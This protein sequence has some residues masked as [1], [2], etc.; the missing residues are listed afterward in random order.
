M[1]DPDVTED[2]ESV[3]FLI[4]AEL[5]RGNT[6]SAQKIFVQHQ[7]ADV[8]GRR[9]HSMMYKLLTPL[10]SPCMRWQTVFGDNCVQRG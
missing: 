3:L 6:S 9:L 7:M 4:D 8:R 1:N 10:L 5:K 2:A